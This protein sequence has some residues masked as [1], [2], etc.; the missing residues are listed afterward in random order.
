MADAKI[1]DFVAHVLDLLSAI[2]PTRAKR[3]FGGWG[4]W[5]GTPMVGLVF[6]GHFYLKTDD[7]TSARFVAAGG[8]P[9][10]YASPR[11]PTETSYLT[12][13]DEAF[14]SAAAMAPWAKLALAAA[15]RKA[16]AKPARAKK[17]KVAK[18]KA[19]RR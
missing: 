16:A 15:E 7:Q 9:F 5:R 4:V 8:E 17:A 14:D 18:A 6:D 19:R 10:V 3:M 2:G 1:D 11:G 12:P 13:P